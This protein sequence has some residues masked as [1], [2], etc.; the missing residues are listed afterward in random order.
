MG[1]LALNPTWLRPCRLA[2]PL[3]WVILGQE[4]RIHFLI[5]ACGVKPCA[6]RCEGSVNLLAR[7]WANG[8]L[9]IRPYSPIHE[10]GRQAFTEC[11]PCTRLKQKPNYGHFVQGRGPLAPLAIS[12][13]GDHHER[14]SGEAG[15]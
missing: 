1:A 13:P 15:G 12:Q 2:D 11:L 3:T 9:F 14:G 8:L 7:N 5:T 6:V 4:D 10:L